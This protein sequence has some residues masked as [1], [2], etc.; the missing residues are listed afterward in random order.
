MKQAPKVEAGIRQRIIDATVE[1]LR[2]HGIAGATA[3]GIAATGDFNQALIFYHFGSLTDLLLEVFRRTSEAQIARY[4][5]AAA[6]VNTPA[7]LIQIARRMHAEDLQTGALSA[8]TQLMAAATSDE[9]VAGVILDRFDD[10][11]AMV[12]EILER[13]SENHPLGDLLPAHEAAYG[14]CA[15]FLGIEL[16]SGLDPRR[17]QADAVFDMLATM[18]ELIPSDRASLPKE[19][20]TRITIK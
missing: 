20:L 14:I 15:M 9:Q 2:E 16:L 17:S 13:V 5:A 11:I 8:V 12:R 6:H 4:R 10:W 3:R 7:E 1:T 18:A 19:L